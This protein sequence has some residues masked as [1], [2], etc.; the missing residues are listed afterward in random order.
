MQLSNCHKQSILLAKQFHGNR[1]RSRRCPARCTCSSG[2]SIL[3]FPSGKEDP[4][5]PR[6]TLHDLRWLPATA[7][8]LLY[9]HTEPAVTCQAIPP[10]DTV[11]AW[12]MRLFC[13]LLGKAVPAVRRLRVYTK[14]PASQIVCLVCSRLNS[15]NMSRGGFWGPTLTA[16]ITY[17][18]LQCAARNAFQPAPKRNVDGL[19]RYLLL[20]AGHVNGSCCERLVAL[21]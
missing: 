8:T 15:T 11:R 5:C 10:S 4:A 20:P 18:K 12:G 6:Y 13:A 2:H 7:Q 21:V 17:G 14:R 3:L 16:R 1:P 9:T 19:F